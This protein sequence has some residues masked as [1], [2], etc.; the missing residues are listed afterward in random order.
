MIPTNNT[1]DP[2]TCLPYPLRNR[3]NYIKYHQNGNNIFFQTITCLSIAMHRDLNGQKKVDKGE[4]AWSGH[5]YL[6]RSNAISSADNCTNPLR[7]CHNDLH[8]NLRQGQHESMCLLLSS[9]YLIPFNRFFDVIAE[10]AC[11]PK[12]CFLPSPSLYLSL[13]FSF[14]TSNID[15]IHSRVCVCVFSSTCGLRWRT[16]QEN[17]DLNRRR[18]RETAHPQYLKNATVC[19]EDLLRSWNLSSTVCGE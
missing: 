8:R 16:R 19:G 1:N 10:Q 4:A 3:P 9:M 15:R 17:W 13:A 7:D 18:Q 12:P 5:S 14:F 2:F 6:I 11:N